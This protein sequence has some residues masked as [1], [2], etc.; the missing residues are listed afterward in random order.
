MREASRRRKQ[1]DARLDP[2]EKKRKTEDDPMI[3][4]VSPEEQALN[5]ELSEQ[6][7][8]FLLEGDAR[9]L[10]AS[11]HNYGNS[12]PCTNQADCTCPTCTRMRL[13]NPEAF[14]ARVES[15]QPLPVEGLESTAGE[16][17]P[18]PMD[19]VTAPVQFDLTVEEEQLQNLKENMLL[20]QPPKTC[21]LYTSP[22]PRD[23]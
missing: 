15:S 20:M 9:D 1:E 19:V 17:E 23:S 5:T 7:M 13:N 14:A 8:M 11:S 22:S 4:E 2:Q 6:D 10:R 3:Q 21:L 16:Q 18:Q 12:V